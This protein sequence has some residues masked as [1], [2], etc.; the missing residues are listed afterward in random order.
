M[1]SGATL[2]AYWLAN[3]LVDFATHMVPGLIAKLSIR[4]LEIDAPKIEYL[5]FWFS[6]A[7]PLCIYILSF[8]FDS[9]AKASVIIRVFYVVVGGAA[10]I[11]M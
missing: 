10:P 7:N 2:P 8:I 5:F 4:W 3:Y 11:A 6:L 1:V 9:D